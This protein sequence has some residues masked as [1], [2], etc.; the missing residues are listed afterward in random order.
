MSEVFQRVK[1]GRRLARFNL[2]LRNDPMIE[3]ADFE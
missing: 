3:R 1:M 2:S